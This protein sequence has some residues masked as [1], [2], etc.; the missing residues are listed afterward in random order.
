[1]T[2]HELA[3]KIEV[4]R[5][6]WAEQESRKRA[7]EQKEVQR[8]AA[9]QHAEN[10]KAQAEEDTR[11]A[12]QQIAAFRSILSAG[13]TANLAI[14]WEQLLDRR[15]MAPFQ[16]NQA[17]PDR[18][19]LRLQLLGPKPTER[20]VA[21]PRREK[22]PW[23]EFLLPFLRTRRLEREASAREE[24]EKKVKKARREYT[25]ALAEYEA[26]EREVVAAYNAAA[27]AFNAK[28]QEEK[29]KYARAQA[30]LLAEKNAHNDAITEFRARYEAGS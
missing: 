8:H 20:Y 12:Q 30:Q 3:W 16:F 2:P 9:R 6:K 29:E 1:M 18:D 23:W 24:Y 11:A 10:L 5:A 25:D 27:R 21:P 22:A 17:K 19:A 7:A 14:N 26:R 28:Y 15:V 13:L 4:Q